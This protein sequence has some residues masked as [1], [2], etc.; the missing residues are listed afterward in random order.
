[1]CLCEANR[2]QSS[3]LPLSSVSV[4]GAGDGL[5]DNEGVVVMFFLIRYQSV[6]A[7]RRETNFARQF[8]R[9]SLVRRTATNFARQFFEASLFI[10]AVQHNSRVCNPDW[11]WNVYLWL[12]PLL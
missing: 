8:S 7:S 6:V 2:G 1:V 3:I 12:Y 4:T 10:I 11:I 9:V 5:S